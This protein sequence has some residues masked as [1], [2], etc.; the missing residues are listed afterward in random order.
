MIKRSSAVLL[1]LAA[2]GGTGCAQRI[3][4]PDLSGIYNRAAQAHD[5]LRN[6]VILIPGIL[7]S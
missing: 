5:E 4:I 2:A 7:G 6:P 3:R 1:V